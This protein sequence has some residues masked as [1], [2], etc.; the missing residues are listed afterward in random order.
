MAQLRRLPAHSFVLAS[1]VSLFC[2]NLFA[3]ISVDEAIYTAFDGETTYDSYL[4]ES[5]NTVLYI[6]KEEIT[7]EQLADLET[8]TK[9]ANRAE[10]IYTF[11][12]TTMGYEPPGG[13][14]NYSNKAPVF[15]GPTSCGSGC[16]RLGSK[17]I[18]VSGFKN[19][20]YNLKYD[21]NVTRDVILAYEFGRNFFT[22]SSK[23]LFPFE[24]DTDE[25]N[26][27]F[28]EGFAALM[29]LYAFDEILT[30]PAQRT[31]NE[32]LLNLDWN[33]GNFRAYINDESANPYNSLAKWDNQGI[34]DPNRNSAGWKDP[35]YPA[36]SLLVGIF[37]TL[38]R[39]QL[40]PSFFEILRAQDDVSSIE[41]A[42]SN[43][44][45]SASRAV[46]GN[47]LPFFENV[48]KFTLNPETRVS[49]QALPTLP[50]ELIRDQ[51]TLWFITPFESIP[52]NVKSTNYLEDGYT[53]RVLLDGKLY[54][55]SADGLNDLP[56]S[57]MRGRDSRTLTIQLYGDGGVIDS[58]D[59]NLTKRNQFDL[60]SEYPDQLYAYYLDNAET[61]SRIDG[62]TLVLSRQDNETPSSGLVRFRLIFSPDRQYR[63]TGEIRQVAKTDLDDYSY[64]GLNSTGWST[65][66]MD[67]P[68]KGSGSERVGLDVGSGDN[69]N[70]FA[71]QAETVDGTSTFME[72]DTD[73]FMNRIGLRMEGYV[74]ESNFRN[75]IFTDVTDTDADGVVDFD[76]DLPLDGSETIDTDFD[77]IGNNADSDDDNDGLS[78][79]LEAILGLNPLNADSDNDGTADG[80]E[81]SDGDGFSNATEVEY[82]TDPASAESRPILRTD[83]LRTVRN[84]AVAA[85]AGALSAETAECAGS[86]CEES[87]ADA[88]GGRNALE[89]EKPIYDTAQPIYSLSQMGQLLLILILM[90]TGAIVVRRV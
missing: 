32:T 55:S 52:L 79:D 72:Q 16:G 63:V 28:A 59:I 43:I 17:G 31:L 89:A 90:A 15:F 24:P 23:I 73:Y 62:E 12:E 81:D 85:I 88:S 22:F 76:D 14:T 56:Y 44:A 38:G 37:E 82:S 83:T 35:S 45:Y 21:L 86:S 53:Y 65:I 84:R 48:L 10:D 51:S 80:D 7:A 29:V 26:G 27:G 57:I 41:D 5:E 54:S 74:L 40:F 77:G 64:G 47:L 58:F 2:S 61:A 36:G 18:E 68:V 19:I 11:F 30:D 3:D 25:K 71:V 50:S 4:I 67:G 75:I 8:L 69:V 78:D 87:K 6:H 70:F 33:L 34:Q 42:L 60:I 66:A 9:L 20:F 1:W 46:N 39:E 49:I 13:D